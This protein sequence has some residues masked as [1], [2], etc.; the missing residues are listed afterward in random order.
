MRWACAGVVAVVAGDA[1][2]QVLV[3]F[4]GHQVAVVEGGAA[5]IGQQGIAGAV[6]TH[7]VAT[8]HLHRI[9]HFW[10]PLWNR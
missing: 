1:G 6:H 2:E 10:N 9:E 4:A 5:E 3:A 8:L 7:L